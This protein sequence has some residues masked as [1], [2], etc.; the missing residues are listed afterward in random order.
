MMKTKQ[1][2]GSREFYGEV[3]FFVSG[4]KIGAHVN[5]ECV[6]IIARGHGER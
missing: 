3:P 5:V 6:M 1:D 2:K 4:A